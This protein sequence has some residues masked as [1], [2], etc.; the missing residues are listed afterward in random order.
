[1]RALH[2][3]TFVWVTS[4]ILKKH[5][6][7]QQ[8]TVRTKCLSLIK[9][10]LGQGWAGKEKREKNGKN[11]VDKV[12]TSR[13]E[14][15]SRIGRTDGQNVDSFLH[16]PSST[17]CKRER[18]RERDERDVQYLPL[19]FLTRPLRISLKSDI[20]AKRGR[21]GFSSSTYT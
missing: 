9:R 14:A 2:L 8:F 15:A 4:D 21:E 3:R 18:E 11:Q 1:M 16:F 6:P 17:S 19:S 20:E 10:S 12:S 7:N 5:Q 13:Q